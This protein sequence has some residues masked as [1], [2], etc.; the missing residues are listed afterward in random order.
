MTFTGPWD[1][2]AGSQEGD[3]VLTPSRAQGTGR[4]ARRSAAV[5]LWSLLWLL[6]IYSLLGPT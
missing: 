6:E 1:R 5:L 3:A 4:G 2:P